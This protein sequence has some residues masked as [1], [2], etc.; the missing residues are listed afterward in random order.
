RQVPHRPAMKLPPTQHM[1]AQSSPDHLASKKPAEQGHL[2]RADTFGKTAADVFFKDGPLPRASSRHDH[3][4]AITRG[5]TLAMELLDLS[6][7][8][9]RPDLDLGPIWDER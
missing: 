7:A 3:Y 1:T 2:D 4:E 9:N 6:A 8:K 5:D